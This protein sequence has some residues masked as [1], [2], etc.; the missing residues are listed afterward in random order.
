MNY[1]EF[2]RIPTIAEMSDPENSG[3]MMLWVM[4]QTDIGLVNSYRVLSAMRCIPAVDAIINLLCAEASARNIAKICAR[5]N[6]DT[7]S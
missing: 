2:V 7:E 5:L 3:N 6:G 4:L 1:G